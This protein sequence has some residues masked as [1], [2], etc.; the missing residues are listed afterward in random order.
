MNNKFLKI[1]IAIF[2]VLAGISAIPWIYET[3]SGLLEKEQKKISVDMSEFADGVNG[4]MINKGGDEKRFELKDGVWQINGEE[5]DQQKVESLVDEFSKI[6]VKNAVSQNE[7]NYDKLEVN[8]KSGFRLKISKEEQESVFFVGKEGPA[9]GD[10]YMRK[11][12]I[13]N[14]YLVNGDLRSELS[15]EASNWKKEGDKDKESEKKGESAD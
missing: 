5:A 10:F 6:K 9:D 4:I 14:V 15:K 13:R 7:N 11:E 2:L 1:T 3:T 8:E 12:G